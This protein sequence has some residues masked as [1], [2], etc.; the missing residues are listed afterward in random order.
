[1]NVP[2]EESGPRDSPTDMEQ[3]QGRF[4]VD[5]VIDP[6]SSDSEEYEEDDEEDYNHNQHTYIP[7]YD[8]T[9]GQLTREALPSEKQ[10]EDDSIN[11]IS[12]PG[13]D[14]LHYSQNYSKE[15]K[16]VTAA[17]D[18]PVLKGK[19]IKFTWL[20][21]VLMR[22]LLNIWGVMLFLRLSW[23]VGQAGVWQGLCL[24]SLANLVTYITAISMS[25]V[26][27]NGQIKG[28]GIYYMISRSLGPEFGAAI[29]LMFT[30]ANS[31]AV[32][33]HIIGFGESFI[34]LLKSNGIE[35]VVDGAVNDIRIYGVAVL[36]L[37]LILA[38]I[39]MDWVT[40]AQML[41]LVI[42]IAAQ[43]DYIVGTVLGPVD[44]LEKSQGFTGYNVDTWNENFNSDYRLTDGKQ[45]SF[46]TV[47]SIYFPSVTG[48]VAGA[49]LSG[50]LKDP[51]SAIPKGTLLAI[52]ITYVSY[53]IYVL[54]LG[55]TVVREATGI[56]PNVTDPDEAFEIYT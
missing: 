6:A 35:K 37:I 50:D 49:N 14:T 11:R 56:Y 43:V 4:H 27:T 42:L 38:F 47:F 33:L 18:G 13:V 19:V 2:K 32:A 24:I 9:L 21:G 26:A 39:G 23:V 36:V 29:G 3:G 44:D 1:M 7:Q 15:P 54:T 30:V 8:K 48:I 53:F 12:R 34:D 20:E 28:G 17:A 10:Y 16:N 52:T 5:V 51:A 40:R 31:V 41:F 46:F 55:A 45:Q 25:A 22:C